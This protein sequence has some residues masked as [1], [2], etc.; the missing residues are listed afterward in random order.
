MCPKASGK[1][2]VFSW[3]MLIADLIK[4]FDGKGKINVFTNGN[5]TKNRNKNIYYS[6]D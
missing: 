6:N 2:L 3:E 1:I 4:K 5:R